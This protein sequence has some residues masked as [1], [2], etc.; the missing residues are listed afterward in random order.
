MNYD[1]EQYTPEPYC[2]LCERD[3]HTLGS[4]PTRDDDYGDES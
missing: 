3:G 4:C 1:D 2:V